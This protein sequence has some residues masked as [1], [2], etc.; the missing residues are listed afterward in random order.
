MKRDLK[1]G[2]IVKVVNRGKGEPDAIKYLG[3]KLLV[4]KLDNSSHANYISEYSLLED[5]TKNIAYGGIWFS[6]LKIVSSALKIKETSKLKEVSKDY[7]WYEEYHYNRY[8]ICIV[9]NTPIKLDI[10]YIGTIE[11]QLLN[12]YN[13]NDHCFIVKNNNRWYGWEGSK[14]ISSSSQQ[15][16]MKRLNDIFS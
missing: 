3:K 12:V 2:D 10:D 16:L 8:W 4:L 6:S 7:I 13:F 1:V 11:E 14:I 15:K 9:F 5:P